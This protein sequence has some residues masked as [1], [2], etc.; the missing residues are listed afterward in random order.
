MKAG[1][2]NSDETLRGHPVEKHLSVSHNLESL[3]HTAME[4]MSEWEGSSKAKA[5]STRTE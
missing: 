1:C 5:A 4:D 3:G 2:W